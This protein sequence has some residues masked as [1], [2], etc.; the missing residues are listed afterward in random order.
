MFCLS[1]NSSTQKLQLAQQQ[2]QA[3][4]DKVKTEEADKSQK[5][6]ELMS[7][8]VLNCK[9]SIPSSPD[10]K[11]SYRSDQKTPDPVYI[12]RPKSETWAEFIPYKN[13]CNKRAKATLNDDKS[14]KDELNNLTKLAKVHYPMSI[15]HIH[16]LHLHLFISLTLLLVTHKCPHYII[17]L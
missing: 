17:V 4:Y 1:V 12:T 11:T 7:V 13:E 5:L 6:Q 9:R 8:D 15:F 2:L 10:N 16:T 3:D 14:R